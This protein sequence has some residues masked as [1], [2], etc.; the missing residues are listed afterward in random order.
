[1]TNPAPRPE[2]GT[3]AE[4]C[5]LDDQTELAWESLTRRAATW[6]GLPLPP[7]QPDET[8]SDEAP[9]AVAQ[10]YR[11]FDAAGRLLYVG[12]SL[13]AVAR[14]GQPIHNIMRPRP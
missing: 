5:W 10:L 2:P 13:S 4:A 12:V 11:H 3:W 14:L 7:P 6:A 1:M 8:S 9:A